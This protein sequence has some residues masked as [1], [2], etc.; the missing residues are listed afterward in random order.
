MGTSLEKALGEVEWA[1]LTTNPLRRSS[2]K[3]SGNPPH[4]SYTPPETAENTDEWIRQ[5]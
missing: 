2:G 1:R 4:D 3:R 5:F